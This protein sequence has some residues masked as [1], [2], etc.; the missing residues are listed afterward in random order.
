MVCA[1]AFRAV[2]NIGQSPTHLIERANLCTQCTRQVV[3]SHE[4]VHTVFL[5]HV[6]SRAT[7]RYKTHASRHRERERGESVGGRAGGRE[8][9]RERGRDGEARSLCLVCNQHVHEVFVFMCV[10]DG[11]ILL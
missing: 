6:T 2:L 3:V 9:E 8:E 5:L 11:K 7:R 1:N 10:C 4:I